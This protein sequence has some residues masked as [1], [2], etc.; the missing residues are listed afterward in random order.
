MKKRTVSR[1]RKNLYKGPEV[2]EVID[3][4]EEEGLVGFIPEGHG[5]P[6]KVWS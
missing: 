2:R 4:A 1:H 6:L 3:R 5:E